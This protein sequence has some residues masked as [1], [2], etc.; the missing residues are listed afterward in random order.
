M[1]RRGEIWYAD[2]NPT[3]GSEQAAIRPVLVVQNDAVN[4]FTSTVV[5][6]PL[7]TVGRRCLRACRCHQ[8]RAL[9]ATRLRGR[10]GEV[11]DEA[12]AAVEA[13]ILFTLGIDLGLPE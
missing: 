6:V 4:R 10:L 3:E 1:A 7:T 8:I 13:C 12:M 2:L 9:D 11:G 5:A